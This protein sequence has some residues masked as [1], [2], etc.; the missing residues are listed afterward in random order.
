[1]DITEDIREVL[2]NNTIKSED[3]SKVKEYLEASKIYDSLIESGMATK[4]G[5][6]LLSR[7]KA[8]SP[9]VRFNV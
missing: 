3:V 9:S 6:N 1:M 7:D 5:N 8:Y 4:R 2:S